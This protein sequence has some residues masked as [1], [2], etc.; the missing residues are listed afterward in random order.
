MPNLNRPDGHTM[1]AL[2]ERLARYPED[3]LT[4]IRILVREH[5]YDRDMAV[6]MVTGVLGNQDYWKDKAREMLR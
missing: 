3:T 5:G 4:V 2:F 6:S 1:L